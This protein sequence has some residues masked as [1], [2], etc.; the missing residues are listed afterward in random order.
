MA[1][2]VNLLYV[3]FMEECTYE[4]TKVAQLLVERGITLGLLYFWFNMKK[5]TYFPTFS[6]LSVRAEVVEYIEKYPAWE[7]DILEWFK[8]YEEQINKYKKRNSIN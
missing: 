6:E 3:K 2:L 5:L 4:E 8:Q 7:E 1:K